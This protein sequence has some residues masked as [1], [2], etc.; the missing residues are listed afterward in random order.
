MSSVSVAPAVVASAVTVLA[1]VAVS[2]DATKDCRK[3]VVADIAAAQA[4][5]PTASVAVGADNVVEALA[6]AA[7]VIPVEHVLRTSSRDFHGRGGRNYS[8][9]NS[10]S[11]NHHS[12]VQI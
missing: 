10:C 5:Y 3:A 8:E 1:M 4:V 2:V 11:I 6:L 12:L 7:A 9:G